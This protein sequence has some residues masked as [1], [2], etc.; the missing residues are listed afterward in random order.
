M[1]DLDMTHGDITRISSWGVVNRDGKEK[2]VL[3]DFGLNKQVWNNYYL[4]R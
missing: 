2:L 4:R 1:A 3:V